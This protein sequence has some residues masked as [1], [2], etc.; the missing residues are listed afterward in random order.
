[1][2]ISMH[3]ESS[4]TCAKMRLHILAS[5]HTASGLYYTFAESFLLYMHLW[6]CGDYHELAAKLILKCAMV[7]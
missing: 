4:K 7:A 2:F 6:N 1:M 5:I 3:V